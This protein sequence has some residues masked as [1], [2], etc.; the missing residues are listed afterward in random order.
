MAIVIN[1][2]PPAFASAHDDLI[3]TVYEATKANDPVTYPDYRYVCDVYIGTTQ[4]ARLK[5]YPQPDNK[6]GVFNIGSIVRNYISVNFNPLDSQV[7]VQQMGLSEF[8]VKATVKFGEEYDFVLYTNLTV[9]AERTYYNNYVGRLV[10]STQPLV[11]VQN[12]IASARPT[13]S[14]NRLATRCFLAYFP[15]TVDPITIRV[16]T[17]VGSVLADSR[18]ADYTPDATNTLQIFNVAPNTLNALW[19]GLIND[20]IDNYS[21]E[22]LSEV[23]Y[24]IRR[25]NLVCEARYDVYTL[26]FLNRYGGFDSKEFSKVSRKEINI[27]K[28]EF[29]RL[30]YVIDSS[31][32][33]SYFN[34]NKVYY[35][36]K[37]TYSSQYSERMTLNTD[38]LTDAEYQWLGDL[39]LSPLVYFEDFGHYVPVSVS[40][41]TYDFRKRINDKLTNLPVN[42]EFG[43]Q[44]NAQ[45]R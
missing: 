38:I 45:Y 44:L 33:V 17:Y 10:S 43:N 2:T 23:P 7:R 15:T 30:P 24:T 20:V 36:T 32:M 14:I 21:I 22:F 39:A 41:P 31:G 1:S 13:T 35:E 28:E 37:A 27:Q 29:G 18:T 19:P 42:I 12:K 11:D 6:R 5:A 25:F 40:M 16:R 3:F 26:H 34:G 4:V 8:F 9:D